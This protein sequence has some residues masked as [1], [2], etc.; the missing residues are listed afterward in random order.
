MSKLNFDVSG[1]RVRIRTEEVIFGVQVEHVVVTIFTHINCNSLKYLLLFEISFQLICEFSR[2]WL[3][4]Y[5]YYFNSRM[6]F[7]ELKTKKKNHV[8]YVKKIPHSAQFFG[9]CW[10]Y[11]KFFPQSFS[12]VAVFE[13]KKFVFL[14]IE[15][16][17]PFIS[18]RK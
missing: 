15:Y 3:A 5:A 2:I 11:A 9:F 4:L 17:P 10:Q 8:V 12:Y 6:V 18:S 7:S 14:K 16:V 1:F 13:C